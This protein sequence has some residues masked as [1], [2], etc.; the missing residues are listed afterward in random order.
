MG[1]NLITYRRIVK[2]KKFSIGRIELQQ[3]TDNGLYCVVIYDLLNKIVF[4]CCNL[5]NGKSK[6]P[7]YKGLLGIYKHNLK[8]LSERETDNIY[9]INFSTK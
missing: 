2:S 5:C 6:R 1:N 3:L 4:A 7:A 8:L 9:E